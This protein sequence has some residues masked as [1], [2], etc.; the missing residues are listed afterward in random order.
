MNLHLNAHL[1]SIIVGEDYLTDHIE[2]IDN[3]ATRTNSVIS[4]LRPV[5]IS[6][7]D[8]V[9]RFFID[10]DIDHY[11]MDNEEI[12]WGYGYR[13]IQMILSSLFQV[14]VC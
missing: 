14:F 11:A 9:K 4:T 10:T 12:G 5:L 3:N 1:S 13:N 7:P 2:A 8:G 6:P